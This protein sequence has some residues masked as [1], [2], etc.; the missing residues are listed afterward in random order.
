MRTAGGISSAKFPV[1][2]ATAR[3][4]ISAAEGV[5][6]VVLY[7]EFL[8]CNAVIAMADYAISNNSLRSAALAGR[9]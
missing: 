5:T 1:P 6:C 8:L 9:V 2:V 3:G 4:A 7:S